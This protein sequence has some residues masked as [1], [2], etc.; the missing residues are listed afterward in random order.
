MKKRRVAIIVAIAAVF[1]LAFFYF[2]QKPDDFSPKVRWGLA[3]SRLWAED[4]GLD[5][6]TV[7]LAILGE[8]HPAEIRLPIY[9]RDIEAERGKYDFAEYDWLVREAE[10]N[11]TKLTL[12][13]GGK[14][15]RWPECHDP[16]WA[17]DL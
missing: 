3:F 13:V 10:K 6:R 9:W 15:P 17:K 7:Y 14:L 12:T 2:A 8:L 5:P 11:D 16:Q 4:M 1:L